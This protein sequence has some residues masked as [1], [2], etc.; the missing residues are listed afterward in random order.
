MDNGREQ[1]RGMFV[2]TMV[3]YMFS[4]SIFHMH[5]QQTPEASGCG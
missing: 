5:L 1:G 2:S 4:S 3:H